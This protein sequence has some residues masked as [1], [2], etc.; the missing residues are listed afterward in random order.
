MLFVVAP[1]ALCWDSECTMK[2][3]PQAA[4]TAF[5]VNNGMRAQWSTS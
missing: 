3:R 1:T 4:D 5:T 2:T